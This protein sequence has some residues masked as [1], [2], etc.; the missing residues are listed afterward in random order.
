[1]TQQL[2]KQAGE[3]NAEAV[4]GLMD[5][6]RAALR[7]LIELRLDRALAARVDASDVVQDVLLVAGGR[8]EEFLRDP[9]MPFHLWLRQLAKDRIIDMHR[10]HRGAQR[11]SIDREQSLQAAAFGDRSSMDLAAQLRDDDLTPAAENI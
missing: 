5:R 10:R 8:L 3:G 4:N 7:R 9:R 6:H 2:L 1:E 11:R